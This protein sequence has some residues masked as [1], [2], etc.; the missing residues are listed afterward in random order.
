MTKR[1]STRQVIY[2]ILGLQLCL[3]LLLTGRDLVSAW[4]AISWPSAQPKFD[5]PIAPGD[6]TRRYHPSNMPLEPARDGNPARPFKST[7]DMPD[8]LSFDRKG[9]VLILTG[10]IAPGDSARLLDSL[11]DDLTTVRLNSP[12]GSVQ[13]ALAIGQSLRDAK[14]ETLMGAEDICLSACPYIL[15]SGV[16]RRVFEGS[17]VGVHQHYFGANSALPA[18]LAVEQ[19]QIGQAKVMK[20]LSKMGVDPLVMQHALATPSNEIYVLLRGQLE[21][22]NMVTEIIKE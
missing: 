16:V 15:A 11:T 9:D 4:S 10:Q 14:L 6:Q 13:D 8:R 19:I 7:R 1:F 17:Q 12:G 18:F 5:T 3:A 21:D 2:W 22:Y 20:H